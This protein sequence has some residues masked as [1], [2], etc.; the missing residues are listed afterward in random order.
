MEDL[1]LKAL[2][3]AHHERLDQVMALQRSTAADLSHIKVNSQLRSLKPFKW[4]ALLT[5]ILWVLLLDSFLLRQYASLSYFFLISAG[6]QT[7]ITKIAV[8]VYVYQLVLLYQTDISAP[9]VQTQQRI[10]GLI[11][12]TLWAARIL[13]LQLP[14]WTTFYLHPAMFE[15][16]APWTW[17]TREWMQV[18]LFATAFFTLLAGWLFVEIRYPNRHKK[19]FGWLFGGPEWEPVLRAAELAEE[20][21]RFQSEESGHT[22]A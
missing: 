12:S 22:T 4:F 11:S 18:Q 14:L 10:A 6:L 21:R 2:W 3:Q 7:L 15:G 17:L 1:T 13:V 8:F 5:G 20:I 9:V 19:W 16:A